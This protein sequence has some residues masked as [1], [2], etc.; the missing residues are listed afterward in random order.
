VH[1]KAGADSILE[2]IEDIGAGHDDREGT[3]RVLDLHGALVAGEDL[4]KPPVGLRRLVEIAAME[5]D[6]AGAEPGLHLLLADPPDTA[7]SPSI[8][9]DLARSFAAARAIAGERSDQS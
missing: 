2:G 8:V 7:A 9:N 1:P 5:L 4:W 3:Q 6:A